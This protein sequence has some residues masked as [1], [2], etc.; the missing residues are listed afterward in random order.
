MTEHPSIIVHPEKIIGPMKPVNG[1]NNG[2]FCLDGIFDFSA[3]FQKAKFADIRTHDAN[4]PARNVCDINAVFPR[5]DADPSDPA[6]YDFER[7]DHY[8]KSIRATGGTITYR[9]GYTIDHHPVKRYSHP[10]QD[11]QHWAQICLGIAK[12]YNEGWAG[13]FQDFVDR[14]EIWNEPDTET[15]P[16]SPCWTGTF[17]NFHELYTITGRTLKTHNASWLVGGPAAAVG[18]GSFVEGFLRH[19]AQTG[20][21]LDFFSWHTYTNS[22]Q[23]VLRLARIVRNSLDEHGFQASASILNEWHFGPNGEWHVL[24]RDPDTE[25]RHAKA[26]EM[27]GAA[28]ASYTAATLLAMQNGPVDLANYYTADNLI[29]FGL[30]DQ[31]GTPL[32]PY[33][34]FLSFAALAQCRTQVAVTTN[35]LPETIYATA[36]R[37]DGEEIRLMVVNNSATPAR[38]SVA[39]EAQTAKWSIEHSAGWADLSGDLLTLPARAFVCLETKMG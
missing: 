20:S 18:E 15:G 25:R 23:E 32:P 1:V 34:A 22:T 37:Q 5:A 29:Y 38:L 24:W 16:N 2:P 19:C 30:F 36:A 21:P 28:A 26:K 33:S 17:E 8:L 7:T 13:G 9:L 39:A 10:P 3:W 6:N 27:N 31:L 11:F 35:A 14:W 4:Y 12:H